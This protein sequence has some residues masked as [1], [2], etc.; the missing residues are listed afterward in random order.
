MAIRVIAGTA[1]GRRLKLVPGEGSR[2]VMDR[3]TEACFSKL[4]RRV[5]GSRFLDLFAGTGSVAIE[6]LSRGAAHAELVEQDPR[7][8]RVI[9]ENL[10]LA[11]VQERAR[12]QRADVLSW[13]RND[14]LLPFDIIYVAPPQYL[15]L[16]SQTLQ[17]IE[18]RSNWTHDDSI[19][20]VQID[21]TERQD[22]EL[23]RLAPFDE[24]RYG[25]T[26]LWYFL[27]RDETGRTGA[28]NI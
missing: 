2:P 17:Q 5:T 16:W 14:S 25:N 28:G 19:V 10:Q 22:I 18:A 12:V 26:L 4:G 27:V 6:A 11:G 21:P 9:R 3:V 20:V 23:R 24:R 13:L 15:G 7:A 1:R 8:L